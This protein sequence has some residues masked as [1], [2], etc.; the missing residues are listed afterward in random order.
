MY[1][2]LRAIPS[3]ASLV[4]RARSK[5]VARLGGY[6]EAQPE[7]FGRVVAFVHEEVLP[8][9]EFMSLAGAAIVR[10][11]NKLLEQPSAVNMLL[12]ILFERGFTTILDVQISSV[13][14]AL[15]D[16]HIAS[17]AVKV[18]VLNVRWPKP[19]VRPESARH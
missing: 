3:A 7:L 14:V 12:D 18:W 6:V 19:E 16:G 10:T 11:Q 8:K 4:Q 9:L 2:S 13:P 5:L 17:R 15:N 1:E